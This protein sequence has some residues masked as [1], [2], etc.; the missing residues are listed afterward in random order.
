MT[1]TIRYEDWRN[2]HLS[3][4]ETLGERETLMLFSGGKDSSAALDLLAEAGIEFG[5]LPTV[6]AGAYPVH[7]Y[8]AHDRDRISEYWS[9]RGI[10]IQWHDLVEDDSDLENA[11]DPCKACQVLRKKM[12]AR[13]LEQT[14]LHWEKLVMVTSYSLWDLVSYSIEHI[15]GNTL[16]K[17]AGDGNRFIE[18]AQRF[19]PA[20]HMKEGYTVFRPLITFNEAEIKDLIERNAIPTL[21]TPC[22]FGSLRPKR[23][24]E[25]Y[26]RAM[27]LHFDYRK[28]LEFAAKSLELP[29]DS[30]YESISRSKYI[31]TLF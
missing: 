20:L 18:T 23:I 22:R 19:Y 4:L 8:P 7:R 28:V 16:R 21:S 2:R 9:G 1:E 5:F 27:G 12:L 14:Q 26:Y 25:N 11:Q 10:E 6:R 30:S 15:L 29:S 3:L 17:G 31:G 13:F 24:L